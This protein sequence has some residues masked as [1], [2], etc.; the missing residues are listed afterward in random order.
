M[1]GSKRYRVLIPGG[2]EYPTSPSVLARLVRGEDVPYGQ[3]GNRRAECGAVVDDVP[4]KSAP[5]L[6]KKGWIETAE[7]DAPALAVTETGTYALSGTIEWPHGRPP[8]ASA[9]GAP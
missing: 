3:R 7:D 6:L 2:I 9:G 4:A 5:V 1:P 8:A